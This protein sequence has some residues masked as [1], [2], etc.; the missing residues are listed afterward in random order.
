MENNWMA[1]FQGIKCKPATLDPDEHKRA[2]ELE[3]LNYLERSLLKRIEKE[4][5]TSKV[6]RRFTKSRLLTYRN[7]KFIIEETTVTNLLKYHKQLRKRAG[8]YK[9]EFKQLS[10]ELDEMIR[11]FRKKLGMEQYIS[12]PMKELLMRKRERHPCKT[13]AGPSPSSKDHPKLQW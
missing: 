3:F 12:K 1:P 9:S 5:Q 6:K 7:M 13:V 8:Y 4:N 11:I 10:H 2:E